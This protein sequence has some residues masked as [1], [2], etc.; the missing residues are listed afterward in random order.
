MLKGVLD[1][2]K[3]AAK[4]QEKQVLSVCPCPCVRWQ[5]G[6]GSA[7]VFCAVR[8]PHYTNHRQK[9]S[10]MQLVIN[11]FQ[12]ISGA[13][14]AQQVLCQHRQTVEDGSGLMQAKLEKETQALQTKMEMAV[15]KER[16]PEAIQEEDASKLAKLRAQQQ[17]LSQAIRSMEEMQKA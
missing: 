6:G 7:G 15:Y 3:E 1:P 8:I 4:L 9:V 16:T 14:L 12:I 2:V 13:N 11:V 5:R 17:T 10:L